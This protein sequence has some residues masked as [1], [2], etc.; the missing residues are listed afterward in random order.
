MA[1]HGPAKGKTHVTTEVVGTYGYADPEYV[2]T[3]ECVTTGEVVA[4]SAAGWLGL[5]LCSWLGWWL[6]RWLGCWVA[7]WPGGRVGGW[8]SG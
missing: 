2:T 1:R 5:W 7:E 4:W 8:V 6:G 3:G